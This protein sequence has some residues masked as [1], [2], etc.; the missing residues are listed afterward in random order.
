LRINNEVYDSVASLISDDES[1]LVISTLGTAGLNPPA[2]DWHLVSDYQ[3]LEVSQSGIAM[4]L[5][6]D[7]KAVN[8]I[9]RLDSI[10]LLQNLLLPTLTRADLQSKSRTLSLGQPNY[11]S[12]SQ[13]QS[14][15]HEYLQSMRQR[16]VFDK[17]VVLTTRN[18]NAEY[19]LDFIDP[20][21]KDM[22]FVVSFTK[23]AS[24]NILINE[25]IYQP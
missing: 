12:Y 10:P 14:G 22:G 11:A 18:P 17:V 1:T 7:Q 13:N 15:L 21:L 16:W 8:L 5:V 25:Y 3:V 4:N 24:K 6:W 23:D 19:P 20:I 2:L 9:N